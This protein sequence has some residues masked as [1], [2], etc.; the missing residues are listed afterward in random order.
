[1]SD[2]INKDI[3]IEKIENINCIDYGTIGSYEAHNAV[4]DC[5]SDILNL[6]DDIPCESYKLCKNG[7]KDNE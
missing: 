7:G 6:I 3:L 4:R 5:L 1:M 2:Y